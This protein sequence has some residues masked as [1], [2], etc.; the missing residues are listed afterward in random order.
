[1]PAQISACGE[2]I[3]RYHALVLAPRKHDGEHR[4]DLEYR[5][6][7]LFTSTVVLADWRPEL[8]VVLETAPLSPVTLC[9]KQWMKRV[10]FGLDAGISLNVDVDGLEDRQH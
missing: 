6:P 10:G 3:G 1:M 8:K 2:G 7:A 4:R 5:P 9:R